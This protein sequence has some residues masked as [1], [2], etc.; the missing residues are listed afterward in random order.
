MRSFLRL[1]HSKPHSLQM[2][3]AVLAFGLVLPNLSSV[4][5][6]DQLH[7]EETGRVVSIMSLD[8]YGMQDCLSSHAS[9]GD[10]IA[11]AWCQAKGRKNVMSYGKAE[12]ITG[13]L[14]QD[15][16]KVSEP[17]DLENSFVVICQN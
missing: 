1:R 16:Q 9:C 8:G 15:L 7:A 12:D 11:N 17:Q 13:S 3:F 2:M 10:V 14:S 6:G 5:R 4:S